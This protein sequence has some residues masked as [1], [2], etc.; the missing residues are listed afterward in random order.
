MSGAAPA[1]AACDFD[2]VRVESVSRFYGRRR[3]LSRVSLECPAGRIVGLFGPNG[4]GK[5]TLLGILSTL[6]R[7]DDGCVRYGHH[8]AEEWGDRVRGRIG[9]LGHDLFLYSDLTA[10]ENLEFFGRLYGVADLEAR[11]DAALRAA[12]L[13]SRADD[14]VGG[15]SRG[16]RQRLALERALVHAPRLVLLDE[17]FTGLDDESAGFLVERLRALRTTGAAIVMATHDFDTADGVVDTAVC[18]TDGRIAAVPD[19]GGRLRER[20]RAAV[21]EARA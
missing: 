3:A 17:P 7:A 14:R 5:S 21:Q 13:E 15:F 18:L 1:G 10:R 4:A 6:V 8:T 11:V 12:R 19:G 2:L 16:L 20:Y 9:M